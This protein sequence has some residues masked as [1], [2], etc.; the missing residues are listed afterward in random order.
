MQQDRLDSIRRW[1]NLALAIGQIAVTGLTFGLGTDFNQQVGVTVPDPPIVPA[2]YAFIIW[3]AIYAGCLAYGIYQFLPSRRTDPLLRRIGWFTMSAFAGCCCW[4]LCARFQHIPWTVPVIYWMAVS[5]Y[6][7]FRPLWTAPMSNSGLRWCVLPGLSI[8]SG[9]VSVAIFANTASVANAYHGPLAFLGTTDGS[10]MLIVAAV[11]L[12]GTIFR[13][14]GNNLWYAGAIFWAVIG[15]GV[16][17][18]FELRNEPVALA[19]WIVLAIGTLLLFREIAL[20]GSLRR[21]DDL[22]RI[23]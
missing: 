1:G 12:A 20:S 19:A 21:P 2:D 22:Q 16:R 11:C 17:S 14:S 10:I 7:A 23:S 4:L 18:Q 5:L 15:I 6:G 13:R 8:Y 9:W 3:S